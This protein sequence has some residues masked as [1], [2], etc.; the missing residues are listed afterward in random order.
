MSGNSKD[1]IHVDDFLRLTKAKFGD[2]GIYHIAKTGVTAKLGN[3]DDLADLS[4]ADAASLLEFEREAV[5]TFPTTRQRLA[6]WVRNTGGD[7]TLPDDF[8]APL[9][10]KEK[11][12]R[13]NYEIQDTWQQKARSI[14]EKW[15][16]E[17]RNLRDKKNWP[18]VTEIAKHVEGE[19][20]TRGITGSRGRFL[21]WETIK[22]HALTGLTERKPKGKK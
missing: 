11:P 21:D 4:Y 20:S 2:Y 22:R 6:E 9:P 16:L 5:L 12:A 13:K 7:F 1:E 17:Q 19:L 15:M 10:I 8:V 14:G 18:G 3:L